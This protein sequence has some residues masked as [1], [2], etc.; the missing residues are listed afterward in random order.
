VS[1]APP[2]PRWILI[3]ARALL[4]LCGGFWLFF[5]VASRLGEGFSVEGLT[6][7]LLRGGAIALLMVLGWYRPR[8]CGWLLIV[9]GLFFLRANP[10]NPGNLMLGAPPLLLG[11]LLVWASRRGRGQAT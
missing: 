3:V 8:V 11:V 7:G 4:L 1:E 10:T 5:I 9:L 2:G 6:S